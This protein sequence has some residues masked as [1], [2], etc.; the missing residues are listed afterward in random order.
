MNILLLQGGH[1]VWGGIGCDVMMLM[2]H[3]CISAGFHKKT[4]AEVRVLPCVS[5]GLYLMPC[6]FMLY[7][8]VNLSL[9]RPRAC[10]TAVGSKEI[11]VRFTK[12]LKPPPGLTNSELCSRTKA[13]HS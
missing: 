11:I 13:F 9:S 8:T 2:P 12:K 10:G 1:G 5:P 6:I 3:E 4:S 7:S